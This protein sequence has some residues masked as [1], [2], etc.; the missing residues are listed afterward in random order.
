MSLPSD[1][2]NLLEVEYFGILGKDAT[3]AKVAN[4]ANFLSV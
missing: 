1:L 3:T 2:N 4:S